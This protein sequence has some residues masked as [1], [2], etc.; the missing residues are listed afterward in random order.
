MA[1]QK[2]HFT[3]FQPCAKPTRH[4]DFLKEDLNKRGTNCERS[5]GDW[6]CTCKGIAGACCSC[7][8]QLAIGPW[9]F[10]TGTHAY[11]IMPMQQACQVLGYA[12]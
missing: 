1:N 2:A 3:V 10:M 8:Y 4:K 11:C 6:Q 5:G 7:G 12:S 9:A